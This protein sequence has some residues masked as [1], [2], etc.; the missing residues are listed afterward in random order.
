[1][2]T[3]K[4]VLFLLAVLL[5]SSGILRAAPVMIS[6]SN[7]QD[8]TLAPS[9][10]KRTGAAPADNQVPVYDN[11]TGLFRWNN[12]AVGGATPAGST[13]QLQYNDNG[14]FR[15]IPSVGFN[16]NYN[17]TTLPGSVS[18]ADPG[19][20]KRRITFLSN[21]TYTCAQNESSLIYLNGALYGCSN[22]R[23]VV[24]IVDN[25][26]VTDTFNR[27]N[28]NPLG[29]GVWTTATGLNPM[30]ILSN[31]AI[32]TVETAH[33][34]SYYTGATFSDNQYSQITIA[35]SPTLG[36]LG[37]VVRW[38]GNTGYQNVVDG[39]T[40]TGYF[41]KW[42]SGTQTQIGT[43]Y[44]IAITVGSVVRLEAAGTTFTVKLNG[45]PVATFTDNAVSSGRPGIYQWTSTNATI[46]SFEGGDL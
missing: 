28:E 20:G 22:G 10:M 37:S 17:S 2:T 25:A 8:N 42:V 40:S 7:I 44:S 46:D 27:A 19:D 34:L 12:Q 33:N 11:G 9:K 45:A 1:M 15:A 35:G 16:S 30:Q 32:R 14:A 36:W 31:A 3:K 24:I 23:R 13:G 26:T 29:N 43:A 18:S 5:L 6:G 39:N 41:Y 38:S 21:T 4:T